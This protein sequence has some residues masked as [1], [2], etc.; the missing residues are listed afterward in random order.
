MQLGIFAKT[1]RRPRLALTLDAVRDY[2]LNVIQ[3][4]LESAGIDPMPSEIPGGLPALIRSETRA[5]AIEIAALSGTF[6]MIHPDSAVVAQGLASLEL[7]ASAAGLM[8]ARLVTLC[9]GTR[10]SG[11][12]WR[13]HPENDSAA[14]WQSLLG[15]MEQ[16]LV[17]AERHQVALGIETEPGNVI[18]SARKCRRLLDEFSSP[19]LK[20]IFD[21]ANIISTDMTRDPSTLIDEAFRF[22]GTDIAVGHAKEC[23]PS[24]EV[25][26]PGDGIVPWNLVVSGLAAQS[27]GAEIPLIIHGIEEPEVD[28]AVAFLRARVDEAA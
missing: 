5:R 14:A 7:L 16:A 18:N 20:V 28:R 23:G 22:L 12:M 10:D 6:N 8:G 19:W 26:T 4:N 17:F 2:G 25:L 3:F 1:F 15:T 13:R 9:T 24:G 21:P 11:N 27:R